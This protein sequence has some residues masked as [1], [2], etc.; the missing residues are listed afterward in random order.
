MTKEYTEACKPITPQ[1]LLE[2]LKSQDHDSVVDVTSRQLRQ[3]MVSKQQLSALLDRSE[4]YRI[5]EG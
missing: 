5:W 1:E 4:L 3:Q 2:L